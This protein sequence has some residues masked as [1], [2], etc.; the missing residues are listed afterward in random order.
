MYALRPV[1]VRPAKQY[2]GD[3]H[4]RLP[5]LAGAMW[6]IGLFDDA[7]GGELLGVVVVGRPHARVWDR[8]GDAGARDLLEVVRCAVREGVDCGCSRLYGAAARAA[9]AMGTLDLLTYTDAD[10]P[11]TSLRAAGWIRETGPDGS[12]RLVG[13]GEAS[14]PSRPRKLRAHTGP[15]HRWWAPWSLRAGAP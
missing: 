12:P 4:R 2:V 7:G 11:G 3:V 8:A 9:R 1:P 6:A 14:R 15:K 5:D 10:E 13:G